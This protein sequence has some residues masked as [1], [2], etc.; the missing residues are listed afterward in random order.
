[1]DIN[2]K[3]V[4]YFVIPSIICYTVTAFCKIGKNAGRDV[5]FRP[6]PQAFGIIWPILFI[7]FGLSWAIAMRNCQNQILCF[8]TYMLATISLALWIY[9]YG[10]K[11]S[12]KGGAWVL[13][14]SISLILMCFAQGNYVSKVLLTPLIAWCLFAQLMNTT[15]VQNS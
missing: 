7:L 11:K 6:P 10:C 14:L 1:M 5:K 3:D 4:I 2:L 15:E 12:I 9:I 13:V 8:T